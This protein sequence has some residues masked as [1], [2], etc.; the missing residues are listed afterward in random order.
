MKTEK[1]HY[2]TDSLS[3]VTEIKTGNAWNLSNVSTDP[4]DIYV[5]LEKDLVSKLIHKCTY[6]TRIKRIP[7]YT[8]YERI[9]VTY[10]NGVRNIY[11]V[12]QA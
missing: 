1:M 3:K 12:K 10:D 6:I 4:L 7:L 5:S 11:T 2:P 8:G 9:T